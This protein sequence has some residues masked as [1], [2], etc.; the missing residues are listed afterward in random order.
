MD[1]NKTFADQISRILEK[2]KVV[3]PSES[4]AMQKAFHDSEK[5]QFDEF[6]LEEGLVQENDLLQ[7]LSEYYQ[8]PPFDLVGY[9]FDHDLVTKFPKDFLLR[10]AII[11]LEVDEDILVVVASDP[12]QEG[13]E[14]TIR[15]FVSYDIVFLVGLRRDICDAVKEFYDRAL[16]EVSQDEDIK[17]ELRERSQAEREEEEEETIPY[18]DYEPFDEEIKLPEKDDD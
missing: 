14:S 6:L 15:N 18:D 11:P 3:K 10:N 8:V 16:T 4:R 7:A 13:L 2:N 17:E 5:E 9:F 12:N 1:D